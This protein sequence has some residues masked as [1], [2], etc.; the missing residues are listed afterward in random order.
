MAAISGPSRYRVCSLSVV[1]ERSCTLTGSVIY[2]LG[3]FRAIWY[4]LPLCRAIS[5][6][7]GIPLA[8]AVSST[9]N[10]GAFFSSASAAATVSG[11]SPKITNAAMSSLSLMG[12]SG[13]S[14]VSP[15][16]VMV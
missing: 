11:T 12:Q 2:S 14:R 3:Y 7:S 13:S 1:I 5:Y 8:S 4:G 9:S 15:A 6:T 10:A 16:M